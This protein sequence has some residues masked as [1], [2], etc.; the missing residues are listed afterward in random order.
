MQSRVI[1]VLRF[2]MIVGVVLW[3][4]FLKVLWDWIFRI[5][6]YRY[7]ILLLF[8]ITYFGFSGSSFIFFISGYLFFFRTAF[9]VDVYKKKLKSRIKTLL[10]PYL[11]W[12]FVVLV[13]HWIVTVLSPVQLTSGAYKQVSDYT[14]CDYLI[15]FWNINGMP[16]NG[17]LWFI[18]DLMVMLAFSPLVYWCLRYFRWY[19][20]VVL[21]CIW[22]VGGTLEIP[23]M[24]A[25]FFFLWEHGLVL[26]DVT[27][28]LTLNLFFLG[29]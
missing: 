24:D 25:V 28:L 14:V 26:P 9:S 18:R 23:R 3:H 11:F 27:L 29:E 12:N 1:D 13:G 22:L 2:P 15:S 19:I 6:G 4:S 8:Y 21:G 17:A 20:L 16:V 7:I 5:Q 10:I